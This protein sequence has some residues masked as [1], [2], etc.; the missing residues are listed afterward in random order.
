MAK[1]KVLIA[2][3][4]AIVRMGLRSIL[5]TQKDIEVVGDAEDG[6]IAISETLRLRPD[7][8]VMDLMM[9]VLNGMKATE[10]ILRQ[11]PSTRILLLT[12]YGMADDVAHA[13]ELGAAGALS[14]GL[15][16]TDL[17][18]AI[19]DVAAGKTVISPEIRKNIS[20]HP[21]VPQLTDRQVKIL[22][23]IADGSSSKEVADRLN[24]RIDS[25]Q[26]HITAIVH[27]LGAS[28]RTEA[29]AIG[30]ARSRLCGFRA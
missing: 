18:A 17:L 21:P 30:K 6:K 13:L 24:I 11:Q 27:K 25:V 8:V 9:P 23:A 3:D 26:E 29:V 20:E 16:S 5:D 10:E 28:N 22:Q 2:D 4:H 19:R 15:A 14:K 1:I 7:V 12:S